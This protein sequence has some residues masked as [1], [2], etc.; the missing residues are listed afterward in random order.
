M[1]GRCC[2]VRGRGEGGGDRRKQTDE[3][4][5]NGPRILL[6]AY[7]RFISVDV[8][9]CTRL[10][11][12]LAVIADPHYK[13]GRSVK[14]R[15]ERRLLKIPLMTLTPFVKIRRNSLFEYIP[16]TNNLNKQ[17]DYASLLLMSDLLALQYLQLNE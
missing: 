9:Q 16:L 15:N 10:A 13:C 4:E 12:Q 8:A 14:E 2:G 11:G 17:S 7:P 6:A 1:A 5:G 3:I